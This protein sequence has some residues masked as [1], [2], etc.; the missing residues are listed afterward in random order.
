MKA[1]TLGEA[2]WVRVEYSSE[3]RVVVD[4]VK[5]SCASSPT[6]GGW[7]FFQ[8]GFRFLTRRRSLDLERWP[9]NAGSV[10]LL[11]G[12]VRC[13][14]LGQCVDRHDREPRRDPSGLPELHD[15]TTRPTYPAPGLRVFTTV[16]HHRTSR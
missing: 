5:S 8:D 14:A 7:R 6:R 11:S 16:T 1:W 9:V 3:R 4:K 10:R 12:L 15:G 2:R 13:V